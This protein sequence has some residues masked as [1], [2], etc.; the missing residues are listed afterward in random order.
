MAVA[1]PETHITKGSADRY[2][3][4]LF[5]KGGKETLKKTKKGKAYPHRLRKKP[6]ELLVYFSA[7]IWQVTGVQSSHEEQDT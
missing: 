6:D 4:L 7:N 3:Y 1:N 5:E 2:S